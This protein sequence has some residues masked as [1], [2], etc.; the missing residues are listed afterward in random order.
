MAITEYHEESIADVISRIDSNQIFLPA[1]Q[2]KFVWKTK[3]IESLFDSI[4]QGFPI[5][6]FLFWELNN[7]KTIN[8]YVFYEFVD[9]YHERKSRNEQAILSGK[10]KI[11]SVLD[12]QQRLTSM[13]IALRGSYSYKIHRKHSSNPNAYPKRYLYLNLLPRP[14]EDFEYEFKFLTEELA[15]KTDEKHVWYLVNKVLRWNSSSDVNEH[16]S[17]LKKTNDRKVITKN[18]DTIKQSLRTLYKRLCRDKYITHFDLMDMEIDDVLDI[19]I[20]V[21][22]GGTKLSKTDL[23][24]STISASWERARDEVEDLL[25]DINDKGRKFNFDID[26]IMR[27]CLVLLDLPILF[28]VRSFGT[29]TIDTIRQK[30]NDICNA[31]DETVDLLVDFGFDGLTLTSRNSVIPIVYYVYKQGRTKDHERKELKKYLQHA[32][33]TGFFGSHGDQA[34][35]NLRKYLRKE[36]GEGEFELKKKRF[37][38]DEL[39]DTLHIPGKTLEITEEDIDDF[40]EY[41]KGRKAFVI[42][43]I[44]YPNLQYNEIKFDQDHIHPAVMFKPRKLR[45]LELD[46]VTIDRWMDI[47]D[48]IPNLQMMEE[49]RNRVKNRTPFKEWLLT[50]NENGDVSAYLKQNYIPENVSYD[51]RNFEEFFER[52]RIILRNKLADILIQ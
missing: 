7:K 5:G 16:Y 46:E 52:R 39:R 47:K 4:M 2:R 6:T 34:L 17:Y 24:M 22:S 45:K 3:Q 43:S 9:H 33:L 25:E 23:L 14:D 18:R 20:R 21:N 29:E 30:W 44:L 40:L 26:F 42:L 36:N 19:F 51:L 41:R 37:S 31:I 28:K 11:I 27:T 49:R 13:N 35:A 1:L 8:D 32:L 15:Q 38:F 48:Q 12:G 10:K 50:R